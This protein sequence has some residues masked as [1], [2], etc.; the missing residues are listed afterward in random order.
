MIYRLKFRFDEPVIDSSRDP[1][2]N[3]RAEAVG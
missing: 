2:S 1:R 3:D